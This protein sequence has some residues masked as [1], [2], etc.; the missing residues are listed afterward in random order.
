MMKKIKRLY[1]MI[2]IV[3]VIGMLLLPHQTM[4]GSVENSCSVVL[5]VSVTLEEKQGAGSS[6]K[7]IFTITPQDA[8]IPLPEKSEIEISAAGGTDTGQ[9][10]PFVYQT[11]GEYRYQVTQSAGTDQKLIY[12]KSVYEVVVRVFIDDKGGLTPEIWGAKKGSDSKTDKLLFVN[13]R[14]KSATPTTVPTA[15]PT[16]KPTVK[17]T[18]TVRTTTVVKKI[19]EK[20]TT[21]VVSHSVKTVASPK[22]GDNTPIEIFAGILILAGLT[23]LAVIAIRKRQKNHQE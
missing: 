13:S 17:P 7:F 4:A 21:T 15:K 2:C 14:V 12:D 3:A 23:I 10:G 22:T 11:P 1:R 20:S 5:P 18:T 19:P 9:F 16:A 6:G 8:G